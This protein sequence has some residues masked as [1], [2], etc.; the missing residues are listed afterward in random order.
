MLAETLTLFIL[1]VANVLALKIIYA[2]SVV[3]Y[4]RYNLSASHV[5]CY[6]VQFNKYN[7]LNFKPF[8]ASKLNATAI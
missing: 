8:F 7:F 5:V 3:I 1:R 4:E 2:N 6:K